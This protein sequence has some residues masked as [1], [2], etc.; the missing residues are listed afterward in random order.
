MARVASDGNERITENLVR[1]RLRKLDYYD[2][3]NRVLVEEQKPAQEAVRKALAA[4]SKA[5]GGGKGAPEFIISDTDNTDFILI[6]ECKAKTK[7]HASSTISVGLFSGPKKEEAGDY[8]KRVT[9][10]AS[11]GVLH[12]ARHLSKSFNVIPFQGRQDRF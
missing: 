5:G 9:R 12:Y 6:I 4:A 2:P 3:T 11:D 7:D 8:N 1:D 10:F